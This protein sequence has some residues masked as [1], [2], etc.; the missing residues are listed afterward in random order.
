MMEFLV[1]LHNI[2]FTSRISPA[3]QKGF[4]YICK[5]VERI[6]L[7]RLY[8]NYFYVGLEVKIKSRIILSYS[9]QIQILDLISFF[10]NTKIK[11]ILNFEESNMTFYDESNM[12]FNDE[13]Y[14]IVH[15]GDHRADV[16]RISAFNTVLLESRY[17][18]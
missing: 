13:A 14:K 7:Q 18:N 8:I 1:K 15:F 11:V 9:I 17:T 4:T 12:T 5:N 10:A 2:L 16:S 3:T 6:F